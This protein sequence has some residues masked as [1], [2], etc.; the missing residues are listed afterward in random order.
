MCPVPV[1]RYRAEGA[2]PDTR[3]SPRRALPLPDPGRTGRAGAAPRPL[4]PRRAPLRPRFVNGGPGALTAPTAGPAAHSSA[5]GAL[6]APPAGP[7]PPPRELRCPGAPR[8]P[9]FRR[10][11]RCSGRPWCS[12][13]GAGQRGCPNGPAVP[14]LAAA[15][16]RGRN[17]G[18]RGMRTP[19]YGYCSSRWG[20]GAAWLQKCS[21][22]R[23]LTCTGSR[24]SAT[25]MGVP[26]Q[27]Q[28]PGERLCAAASPKR[29]RSRGA[30]GRAVLGDPE[31]LGCPVLG[32]SPSFRVTLRHQVPDYLRV[33]GDPWAAPGF[34]VLGGLKGF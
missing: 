13:T 7:R 5:P 26:E 8:A 19:W 24:L 25:H 14:A 22:N 28:P 34:P 6:A 1:P 9:R 4:R 16:P 3:N 12:H 23:R 31:S 33:R 21:P 10:H 2:E 27:G 15:A 32:S 30:R 20:H 17:A 11:R 18:A 29:P